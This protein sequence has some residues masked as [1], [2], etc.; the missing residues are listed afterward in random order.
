MKSINIQLQPDRV[1]AAN[2]EEALSILKSIGFSPE[3]SEGDDGGLYVNFDILAD[4]LEKAWLTIKSSFIS[5]P[6]FSESTIIVCEG[7][8]GWDNYLLLHH[9]DNTEALDD[10]ENH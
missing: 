2:K 8:D 4:D 7:S 1:E 5:I 3:V 9:F 6:C 10:F